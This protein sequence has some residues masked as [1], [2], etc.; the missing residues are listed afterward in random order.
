[1]KKVRIILSSVAVVFAIVGASATVTSL[2]TPVRG[3]IGGVCQPIN[4]T[5]VTRTN[6]ACNIFTDDGFYFSPT[7][8]SCILFP[9]TNFVRATIS[10]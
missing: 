7:D 8:I 10:Q 3:L 5:L 1:M 2:D 4:C 9:L 6:A